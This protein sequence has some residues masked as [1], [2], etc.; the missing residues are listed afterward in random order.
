MNIYYIIFLYVHKVLNTKSKWKSVSNRSFSHNFTI[1]SYR[2][3]VDFNDFLCKIIE[4]LRSRRS[5]I[6][7]HFVSQRNKGSIDIS[8]IA[9]VTGPADET[10]F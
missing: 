9:D 10:N 3:E 2:E 5:L 7:A 1:L 6:M 8:E 4:I